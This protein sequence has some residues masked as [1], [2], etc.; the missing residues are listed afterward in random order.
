MNAPADGSRYAAVTGVFVGAKRIVILTHDNPDP[1]AIASA[2]GLRALL[3]QACDLPVVT[4]FGGI[5]GRAENR[6]L[7]DVIGVVF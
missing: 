5:I 3:E 4:T 2:A 1:D 6:A 7:M